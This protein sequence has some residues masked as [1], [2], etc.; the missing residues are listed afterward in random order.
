MLGLGLGIP[1]DPAFDTTESFSD[2]YLE[3]LRRQVAADPDDRDAR[4]NLA[5]TLSLYGLDHEAGREAREVISRWPEEADAHYLL[6]NLLAQEGDDVPA[7]EHLR[8]SVELDREGAAPPF[9]LAEFLRSRGREAEALQWY[10]QSLERPEFFPCAFTALEEFLSQLRRPEE[11]LE[12]NAQLLARGGA[13]V[14]ALLERCRLLGEAGRSGEAE[15]LLRR[16][17]GM[18]L[19]REE[20]REASRLRRSLPPGGR[21]ADPSGKPPGNEV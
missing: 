13:T 14:D 7:E 5:V 21:F 11:A 12:V 4:L 17:E 8:R 20:A 18:D 16:V 6:G 2:E 3:E 1:F 15:L 10:R 19:S 9:Y